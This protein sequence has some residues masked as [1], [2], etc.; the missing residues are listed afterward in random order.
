MKGGVQGLEDK[1]KITN[2][3]IRGEK[4]IIN[5]EEKALH[6]KYVKWTKEDVD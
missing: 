6:G 4:I 2:E 1:G 3:E 5:W